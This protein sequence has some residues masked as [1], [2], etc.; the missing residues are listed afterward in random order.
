MVRRS[1]R[2]LPNRNPKLGWGKGSEGVRG[3]LGRSLEQISLADITPNKVREI[4]IPSVKIRHVS[5]SCERGPVVTVVCGESLMPP[6]PTGVLP[7][8]PYASRSPRTN[9]DQP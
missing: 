2:P 4:Q 9:R 3:G 7:E 8:T 5:V 1:S 6:P